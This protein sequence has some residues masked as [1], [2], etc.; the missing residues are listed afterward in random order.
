LLVVIW[1]FVING[2][3]VRTRARAALD[4][5]GRNVAL[6]IVLFAAVMGM[7]AAV[8]VLGH[9]PSDR[10]Y[11]GTVIGLSLATIA[12]SWA[13]IHSTMTLRYA[14]LYYHG[15]VEGGLHFPGT[16]NPSDLDFAYFAFL[17]GMTFE[18]ADVE[19]TDTVIR[20]LALAHGL[21]AF[22]YNV[23]IIAITVNV[24]TSLL[25]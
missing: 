14:H 10:T 7:T 13:L 21:I 6:V 17:I 16:P 4:D 1:G 5:P 19:I 15:D 9:D 23:A 11:P 24:T 3:P 8:G 12:L 22:V 18:T 25:H 20:R 2:D